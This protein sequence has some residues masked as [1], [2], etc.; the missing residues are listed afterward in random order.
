M[1]MTA[2]SDR[3]G[4][5]VLGRRSAPT[6]RSRCPALTGV[7]ADRRHASRAAGDQPRSAASGTSPPSTRRSSTSD[8]SVTMRD[9]A[10]HRAE[11]LGIAVVDPASYGDAVAGHAVARLPGR[12]AQPGRTSGPDGV[13]P[14][15]VTPDVQ[16]QAEQGQAAG[17]CSRSA[18]SACPV[19][20][21]GTITDTPAMPTG[22][23]YV[24]LP[25]WAAFR[26]PSLPR[27][28]TILATGP[29]SDG[30]AAAGRRRPGLPQRQH[31]HPAQPGP[32]PAGPVAGPAPV[33]VAVPQR[34]HRRRR[35]QRARRAVR[36]GRLGRSRAIMMM[37]LAA[38]GMPRSPGARAR[39]HRRA[40]AARGRPPSARRSR[41][42]CS[43]RCCGRCSGS[44]S[45]PT[46]WSRLPL[47]PTWPAVV[48][49]IAAAV[50]HR[51]SRTSAS[52]ACLRGRRKIGSIIC[53]PGG[54]PDMTGI[55]DLIA[56][57]QAAPAT[58]SRHRTPATR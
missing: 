4:R 26:L 31:D 20:I 51:R 19:K 6:P 7:Q 13:V 1:V 42:G 23:S 2:V 32:A 35:A 49:P 57:Q 24:V 56:R 16:A 58:R 30:Q 44:A 29:R 53:A 45:S 55:D 34:G 15:L 3:P 37:K 11:P 21:I 52:K 47:E 25:R 18:A 5:R 8:L 43:P 39:P 40:A 38:L 17:T 10:A 22:G 50:R 46:R 36:A 28:T 12:R 41:A 54:R 14:I 33:R 9:R 27:P 48:V